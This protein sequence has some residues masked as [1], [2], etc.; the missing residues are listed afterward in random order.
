[1]LATIEQ[2]TRLE[3]CLVECLTEMEQTMEATI[4]VEP[5]QDELAMAHWNLDREAAMSTDLRQLRTR[6]ISASE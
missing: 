5:N 4:S 6:S 2:R 1:M 3:L